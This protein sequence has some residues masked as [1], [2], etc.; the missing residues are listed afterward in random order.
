ML[1]GTTTPTFIMKVR[2][3]HVFDQSDYQY[4]KIP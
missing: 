2:K 1:S 3:C 4:F